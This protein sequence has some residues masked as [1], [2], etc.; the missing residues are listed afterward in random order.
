M[1][2]FCYISRTKVD[3]LLENI[4][5]A[6]TDSWRVSKSNQRD[7]NSK[8]EAGLGISGVLNLFKG[9]VSYGRKGAIQVEKEVKRHYLEK[10]K[11][12]IQTL[13]EENDV[14]TLPNP[15]PENFKFTSLYYHYTGYFH[16][17]KYEGQDILS[18]KTTTSISSKI[19]SATNLV[20]DCSLRFFSESNTP[21]GK[22]ILH[23]A[24]TSFF[25]GG[26]PLFFETVFIYLH[27]D[28]T[29]ILGTPLFLKLH[30]EDGKL[31]TRI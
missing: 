13:I 12:V 2:Y 30:A 8:L 29:N 19:D 27:F 25:K 26:I 17:E 20:L 7:T 21:D 18:S 6:Q 15:I 3:Q 10:L 23:S 5:S 1:D 9:E 31:L 24:N 14:H 11:L 4:E 22:F 16:A 28:K